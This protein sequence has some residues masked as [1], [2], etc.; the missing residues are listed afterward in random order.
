MEGRGDGGWIWRGEG[1]VREMRGWEDM[2]V[3]EMEDERSQWHCLPLPSQSLK[4]WAWQWLPPLLRPQLL[5]DGFLQSLGFGE[6][7]PIS[8]LSLE[9]LVAFCHFQHRDT[10]FWPLFHT[11]A[12]GL[13]NTLIKLSLE[14]PSVFCWNLDHD[15]QGPPN[16]LITQTYFH[17]L[18]HPL[19]IPLD[20]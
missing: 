19:W 17:Y 13:V 2:T 4:D 16:P 11:S 3:G 18:Q 9:M 1:R 14:L 6:P 15:S 10:S 12:H 8:P 5:L 7:V 20:L